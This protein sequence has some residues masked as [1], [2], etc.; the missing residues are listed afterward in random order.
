M[1]SVPTHNKPS[2]IFTKTNNILQ[3]DKCIKYKKKPINY[4]PFILHTTPNSCYY[5]NYTEVYVYGNNFFPNGSTFVN[6]GSTNVQI[7]FFSS[8]L[9]TFIIPNNLISGVYTITVINN[10]S[11][12]PTNVTSIPPKQL[13]KSNPVTFQ[14]NNT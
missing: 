6:I 13:S 3:N 14:I 7:S 8:N 9:I 2:N 11:Y 4:Y 5:N 1:T 12:S 10:I